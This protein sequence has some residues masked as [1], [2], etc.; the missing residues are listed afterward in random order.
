MFDVNIAVEFFPSPPPICTPSPFHIPYPSVLFPSPHHTPHVSL[1]NHA[2]YPICCC[3]CCCCYCC[4]C[5]CCCYSLQGGGHT[6]LMWACGG[7]LT[8]IIRALLDVPT[9]NINQA[10]VSILKHPLRPMLPCC[11]WGVR[12]LGLFTYDMIAVFPSNVHVDVVTNS[13][14]RSPLLHIPSFPLSC[15]IT[16]IE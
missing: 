13:F 12:G 3:C 14:S 11:N 7:K 9:I 10:N 5:C 15:L 6:A 8:A 4:R 1:T 16:S 2:F